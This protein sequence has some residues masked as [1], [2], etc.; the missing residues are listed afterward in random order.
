MTPTEA[1]ARERRHEID[2]TPA[3][4]RRTVVIRG[5]V[6]PPPR[7]RPPRSLHERA[8]SRPDR[9]ALWALLLGIALILVAAVS[10][11]A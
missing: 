1:A 9:I 11:H 8:G 3:P 6:A 10:A 2:R 4:P 5:Q 7:R